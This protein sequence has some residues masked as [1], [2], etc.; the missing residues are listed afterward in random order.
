MFD[1][2]VAAAGVSTTRAADDPVGGS[3][4]PRP[5]SVGPGVAGAQVALARAALAIVIAWSAFVAVQGLT[6]ITGPAMAVRAVAVLCAAGLTVAVPA[7][8]PWLVLVVLSLAAASGLADAPAGPTGLD[9]PYFIWQ[10]LLVLWAGCVLR[11][12]AATAVLIG[13]VAIGS[14]VLVLQSPQPGGALS[15]QL[16]LVAFGLVALAIPLAV[17]RVAADIDRGTEAR[18]DAEVQAAAEAA[19]RGEL[20]RVQRVLHDTVLNTLA[21]LRLP[22]RRTPDLVRERC[23]DDLRAVI[24]LA[25]P[26]PAPDSDGQGVRRTRGSDHPPGDADSTRLPA[27]AV[28]GMPVFGVALAALLLAFAVQNVVDPSAPP[29]RAW[30]ALVMAAILGGGVLVAAKAGLDPSD[31]W[32]PVTA[33]AASGLLLL[34]SS[35][36]QGCAAAFEPSW[37]NAAA[38]GILVML[39]LVGL[40]TRWIALGVAGMVAAEGAVVL[41]AGDAAGCWPTGMSM[42]AF[43]VAGLVGALLLRVMLERFWRRADAERREAEQV[44][45]RTAILVAV[46]D[47]RASSVRAATAGVVPLLRGLAA[48]ELDPDD[49]VV[50][51]RCEVEAS[52]LRSLLAVGPA[53]GNTGQLLSRVLLQAHE[54]GHRVEL[55]ELHP[56]PDPTQEEVEAAVAL[57]GAALAALPQPTTVVLSA[58]AEPGV[59]GVATLVAAAAAPGLRSVTTATGSLELNQDVYDGQTMVEVT[60]RT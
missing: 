36:A 3:G 27:D 24:A 26:L 18:V 45:R 59:G 44:R 21:G 40:P 16:F 53:H 55:T 57:F 47:I 20:L 31:A 58:F 22:G 4:R 56:V 1:V 43:A 5:A 29:W 14:G 51:R 38:A 52:A 50:A 2:R 28:V 6:G 15:Y 37:I 39:V 49:P 48:G 9:A 30:A 54:R 7:T 13:T 35:S 42:L 19:R 33:V 17:L 23:A 11:F 46:D 34:G 60:W 25:E 41:A 10:E 12:R 32:G 8:F